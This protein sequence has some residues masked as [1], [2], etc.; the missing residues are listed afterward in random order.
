MSFHS[1]GFKVRL[2]RN[3]ISLP[4]RPPAPP[5]VSC[6]PNVNGAVVVLS[7][8]TQVRATQIT[9]MLDRADDTVVS[10]LELTDA[11]TLPIAF[12]LV[13]TVVGWSGVLA[14]AVLVRLIEL[15]RLCGPE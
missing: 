5:V 4:P 8:S 6:F 2:V 15:R 1:Q 10:D 9:E 3:C 7:A 11:V 13:M 14:L 12:I